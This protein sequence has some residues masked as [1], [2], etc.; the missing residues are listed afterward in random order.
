MSKNINFLTEVQLL[1]SILAELKKLTDGIQRLT[2]LAAL[3]HCECADGGT[4]SAP[5]G[6]ARAAD[7]QKS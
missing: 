6:R 4:S 3:E 2:M 7:E 5:G 1:A